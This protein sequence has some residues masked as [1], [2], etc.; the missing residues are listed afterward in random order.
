[1]DR[2]GR[3][4]A[5]APARRRYDPNTVLIVD[6]TL[7]PTRRHTVAA[8]NKNYRY[9]TTRQVL[10]DAAIRLMVAVGQPPPGNRND[11]IADTSSKIHHA[12]GRAPV[13]ADGATTTPAS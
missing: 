4:L 10:I 2:L 13:L 12:A 11:G 7:V 8:S 3:Y 9:A 1:M 5:G 6:G